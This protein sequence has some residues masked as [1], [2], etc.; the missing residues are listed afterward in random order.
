M[1]T[2]DLDT[3][4]DKRLDWKRQSLFFCNLRFGIW[5]R[6]N[7]STYMHKFC[8]SCVPLIYFSLFCVKCGIAVW[9][10]ILCMLEGLSGFIHLFLYSCIRSNKTDVVNVFLSVLHIM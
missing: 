5:K 9:I 10:C 2:A 6:D 4:D 7:S 3:L 1:E 8:T